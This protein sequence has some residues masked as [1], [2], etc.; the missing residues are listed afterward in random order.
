MLKPCRRNFKGQI[1]ILKGP[2]LR[3]RLPIF[4]AAASLFRAV[5]M[6]VSFSPTGMLPRRIPNNLRIRADQ[7]N[8]SPPFQLFP[9]RGVQHLISG[10][11]LSDSHISLLAV[12]KH[13]LVHP[14]AQFPDAGKQAA[15]HNVLLASGTK[16]PA[17]IRYGSYTSSIV[18]A[19]SPKTAAIVSR[20]YRP[21]V[22]VPDHHGQ[23]P[24]GRYYQVPAHPLP[25]GSAPY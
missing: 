9:G 22:I 24:A 18:T 16:I 8:I 15:S 23:Q 10:P 21:S 20:A 4:P 12:S 7:Q 6:G 17:A 25:A 3:D 14:D 1:P 5:V 19:S 2:A 11:I 13:L